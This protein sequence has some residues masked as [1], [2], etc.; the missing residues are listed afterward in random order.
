MARHANQTSFKK[1]NKLGT[2]RKKGSKNK[3]TRD[4]KEAVIAA[5]QNLGMNNLGYGGITGFIMRCG[6]EN[7]TALLATL[8]R[9]L[10]MDMETEM[11]DFALDIDKLTKEEL[12]F[13]ERITVKAGKHVLPP[14]RRQIAD[15]IDKQ[16]STEI[17]EDARYEEVLAEVTKKEPKAA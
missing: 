6:I 16:L 8:A 9:M 5:A 13:L 15:E 3:L 2:G 14:P 10:P 11:P 4:L 12:L 17:V 1:G 7:P